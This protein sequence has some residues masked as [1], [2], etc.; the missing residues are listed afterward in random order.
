ML[1]SSINFLLT[2]LKAN[3]F[4]QKMADFRVLDKFFLISSQSTKPWSVVPQ[5][6]FFYWH[7]LMFL[8]PTTPPPQAFPQSKTSTTIEMNSAITNKISSAATH[9]AKHIAVSLYSRHIIIILKH[10][11]NFLLRFIITQFKKISRP[12]KVS[13]GPGCS[14]YTTRL[15]HANYF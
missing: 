9:Y 13:P 12:T 2:F 3:I 4:W 10:C 15:I 5:S 7:H 6:V 1:K 11:S 8:P 14:N